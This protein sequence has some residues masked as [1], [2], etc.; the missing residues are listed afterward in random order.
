MPILAK[1]AIL[2]GIA[3][4]L[5]ALTVSIIGLRRS[6]RFEPPLDARQ[7]EAMQYHDAMAYI[8]AHSR[9][10]SMWES[11]VSIAT[12]PIFWLETAKI[13]ACIFLFVFASMLVVIRWSN[14]RRSV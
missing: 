5:A 11:L 14:D 10:M 3:S 8:T 9:H 12:A 6:L 7:L 13:A 4:F 2:S 1:A